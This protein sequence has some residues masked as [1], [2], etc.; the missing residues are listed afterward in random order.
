MATALG[1]ES[2]RYIPKGGR[3]DLLSPQGV[4]F[5]WIAWRGSEMRSAILIFDVLQ[6][7]I[8]KPGEISLPLA[9]GGPCI[10]SL[11]RAHSSVIGMRR[12]TIEAGTKSQRFK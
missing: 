7:V 4:S 11:L 3:P 6:L 8:G 1:L 12:E 5:H 2:G 9:C 10:E